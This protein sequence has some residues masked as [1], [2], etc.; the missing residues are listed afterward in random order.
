MAGYVHILKINSPSY[1]VLSML[2]NLI[3]LSGTQK[4]IINYLFFFFSFPV[5]C[6]CGHELPLKN[7]SM[8]NNGLKCTTQISIHGVVMLAICTWI[9]YIFRLS[10][11]DTSCA[12]DMLPESS[13]AAQ[14]FNIIAIQAICCRFFYSLNVLCF[15]CLH[16]LNQHL[17]SICK[18]CY[19]LTTL[20]I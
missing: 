17:Y 15:T 8:P 6:V 1:R 13:W 2:L 5:M 20:A 3:K 12:L 4:N 16:A 9:G 10:F 19:L 14:K 18:I 11:L 7:V